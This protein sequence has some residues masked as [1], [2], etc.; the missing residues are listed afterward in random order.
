MLKIKSNSLCGVLPAVTQAPLLCN[1]HVTIVDIL[2]TF[3]YILFYLQTLF[4]ESPHVS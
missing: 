4:R 2:F 1:L 3:S